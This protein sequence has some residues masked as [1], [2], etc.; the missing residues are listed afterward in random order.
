MSRKLANPVAKMI[1][2]MSADAA[3]NMYNC[4]FEFPAALGSMSELQTEMKYRVTGNIAPITASAKTYDVE[5]MGASYK[6]IAAG[7]QMTHEITFSIRMDARWNCYTALKAWQ[8]IHANPNTFGSAVLSD[9]LEAANGK[10]KV[11][12][13][14]QSI[15]ATSNWD[16]GV[17][18]ADSFE[19]TDHLLWTYNQLRITEVG[20]PSF[21]TGNNGGQIE[22]KCKAIFGTVSYPTA[23]S[24]A[25]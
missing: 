25:S 24:P 13:L 20:E 12:A 8:S 5:F 4:E 22:C 2:N 10:M 9:N 19:A 11:Y 7:T 17:D 6:R 18:G 23:V 1:A 3:S 14:A 16:T 15:D 21:K